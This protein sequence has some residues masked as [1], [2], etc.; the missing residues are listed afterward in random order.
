V[1]VLRQKGALGRQCKKKKRDEALHA[2]Q[3]DEEE[4]STLLLAGATVIDRPVEAEVKTVHLDEV[5]MFVHLRDQEQVD[6]NRWICD[7]GATNHMT[8][9]HSA[10]SE[11]DSK[12]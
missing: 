11:I 4:E 7:S 6:C 5:K 12:I 3:V 2:A 9:V 10:F 1:P 8:G